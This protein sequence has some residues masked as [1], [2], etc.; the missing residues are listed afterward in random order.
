M[1]ENFWEVLD[2]DVLR[3]VCGDAAAGRTAAVVSELLFVLRQT[4]A[5]AEL[6]EH[7]T[8]YSLQD[9]LSV[10]AC[11]ILRDAV[12]SGADGVIEEQIG[13][14]WYRLEYYPCAEGLLLLFHEVRRSMPLLR[15]EVRRLREVCGNL[16]LAAGDGADAQS[17][18]VRREAMR[19]L[20]QAAHLAAVSGEPPAGEAQYC[21]VRELLEET[22]RHLRQLTGVQVTVHCGIPDRRPL[23]CLP[24]AVYGALYAL[25]GNSI[26]CGGAEVTLALGAA[27]DGDAYIL[28]VRDNGPG[29]SEQARRWLLSGWESP[30]A[31]EEACGL[32]IP[33]AARIAEA[34]GG[35]LVP[36]M[37]A[38]G[39]AVRLVLHGLTEEQIL[40]AEAVWADAFDFTDPALVELS[41]L[42]PPECY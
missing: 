26:R 10:H 8:F 9:V 4:E 34:H 25:A 15:E 37:D 28:S 32:G 21:T 5:C 42:L 38:D 17:Q 19:L 27:M 33:Y 20:R 6:L 22:A 3:R 18:R 40:R 12:H 30:E 11:K 1:Q 35:R 39:F 29:P 16:L 41:E 2:A 13:G 31:P 24:D 36:V 14:R 7:G 23:L